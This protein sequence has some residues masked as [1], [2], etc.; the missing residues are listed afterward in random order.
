MGPP[1]NL[2]NLRLND[3]GEALIIESDGPSHQDLG[4][5][6]GEAVAQ[7]LQTLQQNT[8]ENG[9]TQVTYRIK[10]PLVNIFSRNLV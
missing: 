2:I 8:H 4:R 9:S 10:G 3:T 7:T 5:V 1:L 6:V